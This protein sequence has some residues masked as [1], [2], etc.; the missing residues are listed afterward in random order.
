M[1]EGWTK[2]SAGVK[3]GADCYRTIGGVRWDWWPEDAKVFKGCGVRHRAAP[4]GQGTFIHPEDD[5]AAEQAIAAWFAHL[6]NS[7]AGKGS[8]G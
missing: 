7:G 2:N 5:A 8:A 6:N 4:D 3:D 1:S